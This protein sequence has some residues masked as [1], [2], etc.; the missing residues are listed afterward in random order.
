M[1][2]IFIEGFENF[3]TYSFRLN[4]SLSDY[5]NRNIHYSYQTIKRTIWMTLNAWI[6]LMILFATIYFENNP[7]ILDYHHLDLINY[8]SSI[9]NFFINNIPFDSKKLQTD[10]LTYLK[11][12][13]SI[14]NFLA[15]LSNQIIKLI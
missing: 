10:S 11:K 13:Y 2:D 8:R 3:K 9:N 6:V 14:T 7:Y 15:K 1:D 12:L 4:Y 5:R